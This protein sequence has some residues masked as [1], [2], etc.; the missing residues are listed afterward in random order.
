VIHVRAL[1]RR[2]RDGTAP[3]VPVLADLGLEVG[4]GDFLAV[5]GRSGS[6][7]STLLHILGGL[8]ADFQGQVEVAGVRLD[9]LGEPA[10]ARFRNQQVGFVFQSFHLVPALTAL[11]N[12]ALPAAFAPTAQGDVTPRARAALERVGLAGKEGRLP[13]QLS[14]GERQRVAI[15]RALFFRPRVLLCDEPTGNLDADTADEVVEHFTELHRAGLTLV[16]VT[17]EERLRRAARRVLTLAAG[18]LA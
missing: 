16:V 4:A 3:G 18:Q 9:G 2:Y 6:G 7:K 12:V 1:S 17:H 5:V 11:E 13:A 14:G 15:A 10:R 8:D